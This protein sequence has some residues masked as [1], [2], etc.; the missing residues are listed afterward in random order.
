MSDSQEAEAVLRDMAR[1]RCS[2]NEGVEGI[3]QNARVMSDWRYYVRSYPWACA[4]AAAALGYLVVPSRVEVIRPDADTLA[5]LA[6]QN[7]L[8]VRPDNEPQKRGGMTG[9]LFTLLAGALTRGAVSYF[10]EVARK[11]MAERSAQQRATQG[12]RV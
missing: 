5:K 1:I 10:S 2:L 8:L 3:V 12:F 4:G 7:K 6:R 9:A 11:T